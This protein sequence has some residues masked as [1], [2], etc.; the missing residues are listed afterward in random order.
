MA[1]VSPN[2]I[3]TGL[4]LLPDGVVRDNARRAVD[5]QGPGGPVAQL[6]AKLSKA[7]SSRVRTNTRLRLD[8]EIAK[9]LETDARK[10]LVALPWELPAA[11]PAF[12]LPW[13]ASAMR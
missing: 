12:V 11:S 6:L 1:A 13:E 7:A 9:C 10:K 3:N 5:L 8:A 2:I 4:S